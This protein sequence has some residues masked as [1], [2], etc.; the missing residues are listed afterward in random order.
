MCA[1]V[2]HFDNNTSQLGFTFLELLNKNAGEYSL[3]NYIATS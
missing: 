2:D 1:H 3:P